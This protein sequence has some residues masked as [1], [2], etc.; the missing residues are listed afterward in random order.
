MELAIHIPCLFGGNIYMHAHTSAH[1]H[2]RTL[3]K[4]IHSFIHVYAPASNL[5]VKHVNTWSLD[6]TINTWLSMHSP[7]HCICGLSSLVQAVTRCQQAEERSIDKQRSESSLQASLKVGSASIHKHLVSSI[8]KNLAI[9]LHLT[10]FVT[11]AR[12]E[13]SREG[14]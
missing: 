5:V 9:M 8:Y 11:I 13:P 4:F 6:P 7:W 3:G 12:A 1:Q 14:T 10:R 2:A